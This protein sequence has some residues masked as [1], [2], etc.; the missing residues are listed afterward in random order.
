MLWILSFYSDEFLKKFLLNGTK[1]KKKKVFSISVGG[2]LFQNLI[3][4]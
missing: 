1:K 3:S 2:V 4:V